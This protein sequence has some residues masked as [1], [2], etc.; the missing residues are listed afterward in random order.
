MLGV[1]GEI[2]DDADLVNE[3]LLCLDLLL[4]G[5][6]RVCVSFHLFIV[7]FHFY[8]FLFTDHFVQLVDFGQLRHQNLMLGLDKFV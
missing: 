8:L 4:Q 1:T 6:D 3:G 2:A 7:P 5:R